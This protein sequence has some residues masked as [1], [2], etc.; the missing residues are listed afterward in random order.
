MS[1]IFWLS[2]KGI[3]S[4]RARHGRVKMLRGSVFRERAEETVPKAVNRTDEKKGIGKRNVLHPLQK[5]KTPSG[6]FI[7]LVKRKGILSAKY[8]KKLFY[9]RLI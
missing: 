8:L 9:L 1:L 4:D 7:F 6:V 2:G 3:E 5:I